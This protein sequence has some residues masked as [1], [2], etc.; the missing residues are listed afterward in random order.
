M[1]TGCEDRTMNVVIF[2]PIKKT[3]YEAKR[4]TAATELGDFEASGTL[5]G[6]IDFVGPFRGTYP[7]T[8]DEALAIIV[9]LKQAREDVLNN[10]NPLGDP[11]IIPVVTVGAR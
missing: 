11:R 5:C 7:L 2:T 9:M 6:H 3:L 8:P 10:S 4:F 1:A